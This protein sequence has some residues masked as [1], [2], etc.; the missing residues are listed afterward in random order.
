MRNLILTLMIWIVCF[1]AITVGA[2]LSYSW[3][4]NRGENMTIRFK[5]VDGLVPNQ[6]KV[7]YKGVQIGSVTDIKI[8][9]T[10][11][12]PVI[13]VRIDKEP[14]KIIGKKSSFWIVRPEIG[15]GE[16]RNLSAIATGDYIE[17]NPVP[18][19]KPEFFVGL[20]DDP[21]QEK[22]ENSLKIVLKTNSAA[23]LA[24][25]SDVLYRDFKIGQIGEMELSKDKRFILLNVYIDQKYSQV[26]RKNSY[27][28]NISG[29]H[30]SLHIFGG[31]EI[32]LNSLNTLIN[33]GITVTTPNFHAPAAR[34]NDVYT[35]L[36]KQEQA[37]LN[38]CN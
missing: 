32:S 30:A 23:G 33:G 3:Y 36:T 10:N 19:D 20:N 31:S 4:K 35:L 28:A 16:I 13:A 22:F 21:V 11:G 1:T 37:E 25:G 26:V 29:F 24:V 15:L 2:S 12:D 18:G 6:S 17:V 9:L 5:N 7:V 14:A 8:D 34:N 27:F 38:K